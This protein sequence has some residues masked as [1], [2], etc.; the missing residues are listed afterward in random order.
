LGAE[1]G[2]IALTVA[3]RRRDSL[4]D[5]PIPLLSTLRVEGLNLDWTGKYEVDSMNKSLSCSKIPWKSYL[6][7]HRR[8]DSRMKI[9]SLVSFSF[10]FPRSGSGWMDGHSTLEI[11]SNMTFAVSSGVGSL[12][13]DR[14]P[15]STS[16]WIN[17]HAAP[18]FGCTFGL[19]RLDRGYGNGPKEPRL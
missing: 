15:R 13:S 12:A 10:L 3:H 6:G 18:C 4:P 11:P 17:N 2:G 1:C 5:I 8:L 19:S 7:S 9:L 14:T 16:R